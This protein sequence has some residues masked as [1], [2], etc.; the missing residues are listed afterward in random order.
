M[1]VSNT[2]TLAKRFSLSIDEIE[3]AIIRFYDL[4]EEAKGNLLRSQFDM[5]I[6][7]LMPNLPRFA[8]FFF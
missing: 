3:E 7:D 4:D 2:A 1:K 5:I 6:E 8:F